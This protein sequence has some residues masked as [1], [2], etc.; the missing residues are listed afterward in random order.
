MSVPGKRKKYKH[1]VLIECN[2]Y[3]G[4]KEIIKN[5]HYTFWTSP[6]KHLLEGGANLFDRCM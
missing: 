3:L 1:S 2:P 5:N 4:P 6:K